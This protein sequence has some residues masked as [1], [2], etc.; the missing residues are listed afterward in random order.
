MKKLEYKN[1]IRMPASDPICS[2]SALGNTIIGILFDKKGSEIQQTIKSRTGVI[3]KKI[4]EYQGMLS[5][6]DKFVEEKKTVLEELDDFYR[7]QSDK[8]T[9]FLK[10]YQDSLEVIHKE[11]NDKTGKVNKDMTDA[12]FAFDKDTSK[13]IEKKAVDFEKSFDDFKEIFSDVNDFLEEEEEIVEESVR[14]IGFRRVVKG[15]Y[16][17]QGVTGC[18]GTSGTDN[19]SVQTYSY[20]TPDA[21]V[22]QVYVPTKED[23]VTARLNTLRYLLAKYLNH[24]EVLKGSIHKLEEE[25][26]RLNLISG[27]ISPDREYKLDLNK[28]SAFG[29]E[30]VEVK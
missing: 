22:R 29:F 20:T 12:L 9:A 13:Q 2:A 3:D 28:L 21:F 8:K 10:P 14:G 17:P 6:V 19:D 15:L 23:E 16:G 7:D 1:P 24:V 26:R 25:K 30:D 11:F 5:K 18:Q 27:N 4:D